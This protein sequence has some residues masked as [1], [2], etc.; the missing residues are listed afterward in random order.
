MLVGRQLLAVI[1]RDAVA[2]E[3]ECGERLG[4]AIARCG[5]DLGGADAQAALIEVDAVE[6]SAQLDQRR[7]AARGD[8]GDDRA[9]LLDDV[10][11]RLPLGK[12]KSLKAL[13]K[14]R[15]IGVEAD[16]HRVSRGKAGPCRPQGGSVNPGPIT[17]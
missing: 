9:R 14:I 17:H 8:I 16:R 12:Q 15:R 11:G 13:G 6:C 7:V 2:G 1:G 5:F 10:L 3:C 4:I